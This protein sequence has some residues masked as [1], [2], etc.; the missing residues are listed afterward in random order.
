M[1]KP[2]Q[3][4]RRNE[5]SV[6]VLHDL[7]VN[8]QKLP[9]TNENGARPI[10]VALDD[11]LISDVFAR[12]RAVGP[13]ANLFVELAASKPER[14][15][16]RVVLVIASVG[17]RTARERLISDQPM[18]E[19]TTIGMVVEYVLQAPEGVQMLVKLQKLGAA[20]EAVDRP[21]LVSA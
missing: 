1:K 18:H 14:P 8:R 10:V 16:K 15:K 7:A 11:E 5:L 19:K 21:D 2:T 9:V 20:V 17:A 13:K 6:K 3:E 12:V 4:E